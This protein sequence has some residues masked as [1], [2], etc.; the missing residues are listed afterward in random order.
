M[1]WFTHGG[2]TARSQKSANGP[3]EGF[4]AL[5]RT[6]LR[7]GCQAWRRSARPT[8]LCRSSNGKVTVVFSG[9]WTQPA[10]NQVIGIPACITRRSSGQLPGGAPAAGLLK[11]TENL[12]LP[13]CWVTLAKRSPTFCAPIES[14]SLTRRETFRY[15]RHPVESAPSAG[16]V[17]PG[18]ATSSKR[19]PLP[20][21]IVLPDDTCAV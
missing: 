20:S 8:P 7:D 14:K 13:P 21:A 18:N 5:D 15:P 4:K 16:T 12:R 17:A 11:P 6:G 9:R 3:S 1:Q 10:G 19:Q 2:S